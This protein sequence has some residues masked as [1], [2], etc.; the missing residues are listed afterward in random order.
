MAITQ[1]QSISAVGKVVTLGGAVTVGQLIIV[2]VSD[3]S[4]GTSATTAVTDNKGNTYTKISQRAASDTV[5]VFSCVVATGGSSFTITVTSTAGNVTTCAQEFDGF[6]GTPTLDQQA[7][8]RAFSNTNPT[9]TSAGTTVANELVVGSFSSADTT[10]AVTL[11]AGYSSLVN[12]VGTNTQSGMESKII[13]STGAQTATDGSTHG[14]WTA[15]I[16]TFYDQ[17]VASTLNPSVSDSIT[18]TELVDLG[19]HPVFSIFDSVT[20]SENI[21][22]TRPLNIS[23]FEQIECRDSDRTSVIFNGVNQYINVPDNDAFSFTTNGGLTISFLVHFNTLEF[24]HAEISVDGPYVE[25]VGKG[26]YGSGNE[27]EYV[28]RVYSKSSALR[29]NRCS[30]YIFNEHAGTGVGS[31]FQDTLYVGQWIRITGALDATNTYIYR[32]GTLRDTDNYASFPIVPVNTTSPFRIGTVTTDSFIEAEI[33]DLLVYNRKLSDAEVAGLDTPSRTSSGLVAWYKLTDTF[34]TT[35]PDS[36]GNGFDGTMVNGPLQIAT[37]STLMS[38]LSTFSKFDTVTVSESVSIVITNSL[39]PSPVIIDNINVSEFLQMRTS[40]NI[41]ISDS[42]ITYE[43]RKNLVLNPDFEINTTGWG[44]DADYSRVNTDSF[45][46]SWSIK[47]VSSSGFANFTTTND[48][49]GWDVIPNHDY[50]LSFYYKLT[51]NFAG[52]GPNFE[53]NSI[54]AFGTNITTGSL[55]AQAS[56][57]RKTISFNSGNNSKIW[58]RL[59]NNNG[60]VVGFYDAFQLE[61]GLAATTYFD[62]DSAGATWTGTQGLSVSQTSLE[63][64]T[65]SVGNAPSP[66]PISE[67]ITVSENINLFYPVLNIGAIGSMGM[68]SIRSYDAMKITKDNVASQPT[69]AYIDS[70]TAFVKANIRGVTHICVDIPF[71]QN[72]DF[73]SNG[74]TPSPRT[75]TQYIQK[76]ADSVHGVGLNVAWRQT[77][78]GLEGLYS[79]PPLIGPNRFALGTI[80]TAATDGQ[81]SLNGKMYAFIVS[82]PTA[83]ADKDLWEPFPESTSHDP[84]INVFSDATSF[85]P[86]SGAGVQAN[87]TTFFQDVGLVAELAFSVIGKK[88]ICR[89]TANNWSEINTGWLNAGNFSFPQAEVFDHYGTDGAGHTVAEMQS[90]YDVAY[91]KGYHFYHQEWSDYWNTF[92]EKD[93]VDYQ[94]AMFKM[95]GTYDVNGKRFGFNSWSGWPDTVEST[96]VNNG[97]GANPIW[98]LNTSGKVLAGAFDPGVMEMITVSENISITL[99]LQ[100][101]VFDSITTTESVTMT[102]TSNQL[103]SDSITTTEN[104]SMMVF[105]L[106]SVSD[107]ITTSESVQLIV[108]TSFL[109]FD[110]TTV[111]E[112][113]SFNI[114]TPTSG[115]LFVSDLIGVNETVGLNI[116]VLF[117]SVSDSTTV[118]ENIAFGLNPMVSVFDATTISESVSM[119]MNISIQLIEFV[120]QVQNVGTHGVGFGQ[121]AAVRYRGQGFIPTYSFLSA[122]E[123]QRN[124]GSQGIKVYIDT[125]DVNSLPLHAVGSELYSFVIPFS[126][127][128]ASLTKYNL[129]VLLPVTP[130]V[131]YVFYLAPW[132]TTTN[133]Y[134]DDYQDAWFQTADV[135]PRGKSP[136]NTNGTWAVSDTGN[137]DMNF[138]TY[139]FAGDATTITDSPNTQLLSY[140]SV[141][142]TVTVLELAAPIV[143]IVPMTVS[144]ST[145]VSEGITISIPLPVFVQDSI[146]VSEFDNL[147]QSAV[148]LPL[149]EDDI[150]VSDSAVVSIFFVPSVVPLIVD[151]ISVSEHVSMYVVY[152][153]TRSRK[154]LSLQDTIF[155]IL[156][157]NRQK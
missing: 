124:L 153:I 108:S 144:D 22:M 19:G 146:T 73:I 147:L 65:F 107:S 86:Y 50:T 34:G 37:D 136:I 135:Y 92:N 141:F 117:L 125:A 71:D 47:Q 24:S 39:V 77:L 49:V 33:K 84:S 120:D 102:I 27:F 16:V 14:N 66:T 106:P 15:S 119:N 54:S 100:R 94:N 20:V 155:Y 42:V 110:S 93:R 134:Q 122:I 17:A 91:A 72:S 148:I 90:G 101:S 67:N 44:L 113:A 139:G 41:L 13:S 70:Y 111:S 132:N 23:V 8:N 53:V 35:A 137:L 126:Q 9:V 82:M 104:I 11:G 138:K 133:S 7:T 43:S 97:T 151:N 46:G 36:S 143:P 57:T 150:S 51:I 149:L 61:L 48:A 109:V 59:Y 38:P 3:S 81:N 89:Y 127:L 55:L 156:Q 45:S 26:L 68:V 145:T 10:T 87:Y 62:G 29:S 31:Y 105:E 21:S 123:F 128:S 64:I 32:D 69:D 79:F 30:F 12:K 63:D 99:A 95:M 121:F 4:G 129:P 78:C 96:I 131:Q 142:D 58:F 74:T 98:A 140:I 85:I 25:Y 28:F 103:V 6:T 5:T 116:T 75:I 115:N 56:W 76:W 88:V 52:Q 112:F 83:F 1:G 114:L 118:S 60:N 154:T 130:G 2:T 157:F 80:L 152:H 18:I 40:M